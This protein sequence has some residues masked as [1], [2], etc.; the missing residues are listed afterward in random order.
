MG[1]PRSLGVPLKAQDA[2]VIAPMSLDHLYWPHAQVSSS[3]LALWVSQGMAHKKPSPSVI[4]HPY[5]F[6]G[7]QK[8]GKTLTS[9]MQGIKK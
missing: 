8:M 6:K 2:L 7:R 9:T 1:P 5:L 3:G 4:S